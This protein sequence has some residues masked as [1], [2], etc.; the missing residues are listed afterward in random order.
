MVSRRWNVRLRAKVQDKHCSER[1]VK[2]YIRPMVYG[3]QR[4][5]V[6]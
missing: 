2:E 1:L 5:S 3:L 6:G 4:S